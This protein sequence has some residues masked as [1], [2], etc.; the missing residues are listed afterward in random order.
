MEK[1]KTIVFRT[2][3]SGFEFLETKAKKLGI[4]KSEVA[5]RMFAYAAQN[6]TDE[7]YR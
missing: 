6:M 2:K 7:D 4:A 3:P 5:R 1:E